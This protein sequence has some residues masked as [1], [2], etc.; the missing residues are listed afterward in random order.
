MK[1]SVGLREEERPW[2]PVRICISSEKLL[3]GEVTSRA[4]WRHPVEQFHLLIFMSV[5]H[6]KNPGT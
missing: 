5:N 3:D 4:Q 6:G 1:A 2:V